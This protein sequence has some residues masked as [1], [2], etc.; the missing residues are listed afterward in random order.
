MKV[1]QVWEF[2]ENYRNTRQIARLGLAISKM[3]YFNEIADMVEP[4]SPRA[5]G[6]LPTIAKCGDKN[7]QIEIALKV[8]KDVAQTKSYAEQNFRVFQLKKQL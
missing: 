7:K 2:K 6:P 8:A 1:P 5:D 4:T 3:P